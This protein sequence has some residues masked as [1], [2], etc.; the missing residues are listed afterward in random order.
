MNRRMNSG[1]GSCVAFLAILGLYPV[2]RPAEGHGVG[3]GAIAT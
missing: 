3:I 1:V 2:I